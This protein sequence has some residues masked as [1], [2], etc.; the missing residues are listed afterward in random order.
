MNS[1]KQTD[2][3]SPPD[4]LEV[5]H[6]AL[7]KLKLR[8]LR[9]AP[10]IEDMVDYAEVLTEDLVRAAKTKHLR[11]VEAIEWI[12][13][14]DKEWP[15]PARVIEI[16]KSKEKPRDTSEKIADQET[17]PVK[18]AEEVRKIRVM[19]STVVNSGQ[20]E[21]KSIFT[22]REKHMQS[23]NGTMPLTDEQLIEAQRI[24]SKAGSKSERIKA[25]QEYFESIGL[26]P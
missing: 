12:G 1:E 15:Q 16:M 7:G 20:P 2:A 8:R 11:I 4:L 23:E 10:K 17:D 21:K 14:N 3:N 6:E 24:Y 13:G 19:A 18:Q 25:Q 5:V 22:D 26:K 9:F